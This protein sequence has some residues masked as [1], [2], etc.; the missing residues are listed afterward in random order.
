MS[1]DAEPV[2]DTPAVPSTPATEPAPQ[3]AIQLKSK[4]RV[5][6]LNDDGTVATE[7]ESWRNLPAII[8]AL[9]HIHTTQPEAKVRVVV[10]TEDGSK[11]VKQADG[12]MT[13]YIVTEGSILE[14]VKKLVLSAVHPQRAVEEFQALGSFLADRSELKGVMITLVFGDA[15]VAGFGML[16]S[17]AD[18]TD[19]DIVTLVESARNQT[20]QMKDEMQKKRPA[21]VFPSDKSRIILPSEFRR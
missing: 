12:S 16:S 2:I 9:A 20:D 8:R 15:A 14:A 11:P 6:V 3:R 19:A 17:T 4:A 21:L 1:P 18:V 13:D 7:T 5:Q 10:D